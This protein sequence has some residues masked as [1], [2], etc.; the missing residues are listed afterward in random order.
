[1]IST[2]FTHTIAVEHSIQNVIIYIIII[3]VFCNAPHLVLIACSG[4]RK[5]QQGGGFLLSRHILFV[6]S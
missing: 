6:C 5:M 1:M 4:M 3:T 2:V